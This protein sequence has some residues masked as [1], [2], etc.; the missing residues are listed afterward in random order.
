VAG[1]AETDVAPATIRR[2]HGATTLGLQGG[3]LSLFS[4]RALRMLLPRVLLL[5]PLWLLW[6]L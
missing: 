3:E 5:L 4:R 2:D 1:H 6:L